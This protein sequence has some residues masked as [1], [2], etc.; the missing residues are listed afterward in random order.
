MKVIAIGLVVMMI[1][2]AAGMVVADV[3]DP[4]EIPGVG[5]EYKEAPTNT[6]TEHETERVRPVYDRQENS[7]M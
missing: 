1:L 3:D 4:E 5:P 6:E 7:N 2:G